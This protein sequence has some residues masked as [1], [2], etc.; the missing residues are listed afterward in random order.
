MDPSG[1]DAD[2]LIRSV[3]LGHQHIPNVRTMTDAYWRHDHVDAVAIGGVKSWSGMFVACALCL[4]SDLSPIMFLVCFDDSLWIR[5]GSPLSICGYCWR[6]VAKSSVI[7]LLVFPSLLQFRPPC[8][9]SFMRVYRLYAFR[10][11]RVSISSFCL[12][13][14]T[15]YIHIVGCFPRMTH[16]RLFAVVLVVCFILLFCC[17]V[18]NLSRLRTF[19]CCSSL[20]FVCLLL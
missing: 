19:G 3:F 10:V 2:C 5:D 12:P 11:L 9:Y 1:M 7:V 16:G 15:L 14:A 17:V 6:L 18:L 4:S 13:Y 20:V 8:L